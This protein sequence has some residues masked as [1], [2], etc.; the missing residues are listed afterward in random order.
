MIRD[1]INEIDEGL[2]ELINALINRA[3]NTLDCIMPMYTHLQQ[4]QIGLLAHYMLAYA[5]MLFRDVE[6]L[7]DCYERVNRSPLGAGAIG[8]TSL[9]IDRNMIARLLAFNTLIENSI[10]ATS[11]RDFML[12]FCFDLSS[13]MLNLSRMAED[14]IIWSSSEFNYIELPDE[15][16]STSSIMPQKKNPCPLELL[17]A[18]AASVVGDL[19]SIM[20]TIKS[21]PSGYNRDLQDTKKALFRAIR[22]S[23]DSIEIMRI[24]IER[25]I[26]KKEVMIEKAS[27][28]YALALDLA[29]MLVKDGKPFREAHRIVGSLVMIASNKGKSLRE[30]TADEIND[31]R[32]Y[33]MMKMLDV[34]KVV[35]TRV[36]IGSANP[37]EDARMIDERKELLKKHRERLSTRVNILR[38]MIKAIEDKVI[39]I[40]NTP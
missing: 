18:R 30:L 35:N 33:S 9:P 20:M 34:N 14:L 36:S 1:E 6:R 23:K 19:I 10:D 29:E 31:E 11:S 40:I 37:S 38:D 24:I 25:M 27:N 4:A 39:T 13:I 7:E 3:E 5:D 26:P 32:I 15:L 22:V 28:S 21:L 8:G 12:E 16:A 17:R 2:L